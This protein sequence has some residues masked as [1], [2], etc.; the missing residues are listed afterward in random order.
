M[1]DCALPL[2]AK[3]NQITTTASRTTDARKAMPGFQ[4]RNGA[5]H[6]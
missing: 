4:S 1:S 5:R 2:P 3:T 6:R